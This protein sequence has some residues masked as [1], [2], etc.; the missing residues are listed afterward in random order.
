MLG[1]QILLLLLIAVETSR[2]LVKHTERVCLKFQFVISIS[3][4]ESQPGIADYR[5][6][7]LGAY[8]MGLTT[9]SQRGP[10]RA[11]DTALWT[12]PSSWTLGS[13]WRSNG[14]NLVQTTLSPTCFQ[15]SL[16]CRPC[17]DVVTRSARHR[18]TVT[19]RGVTAGERRLET[20]QVDHTSR[21]CLLKDFA[22]C[23]DV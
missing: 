16:L 20:H 6:C 19:A 15:L 7:Q 8:K 14:T 5:F 21:H 18:H 11:G 12:R 9:V 10:T 1:R 3:K 17:L 22:P 2:L 13:A 23:F 4:F